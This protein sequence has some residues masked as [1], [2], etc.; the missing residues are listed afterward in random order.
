MSETML[1]VGHFVSKETNCVNEENL[2][3]CSI[4][5]STG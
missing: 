2:R 1:D 4:R 3:S 5:S